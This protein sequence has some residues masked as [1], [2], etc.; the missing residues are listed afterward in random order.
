[1]KPAH[2]L[3]FYSCFLAPVVPK[4]N[5]GLAL[6]RLARLSYPPLFVGVR[7]YFSL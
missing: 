2:S 6:H 3:M 1:M 5:V 7:S 4:H